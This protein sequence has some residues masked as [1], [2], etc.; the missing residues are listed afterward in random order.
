MKQANSLMLIVFNEYQPSFVLGFHGCDEEVG[1][2]ILRGEEDH[3]FLSEKNHDWLG[4]GIYFWEGNPSRA[5]E[6][7]KARHKLGKIQSPFVLGAIIDL[8]HCLDLFDHDGLAQVKTAHTLLKRTFKVAGKA[9]FK[10]SGRTPDKAGRVLDC[11]V[12]NYLHEYRNLSDEEEYD[13]VR[14][15]FLEG[16]KL[17][18]GAGFRSENHIQLCVRKEVCIKGYFRPLP[19]KEITLAQAN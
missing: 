8:R 13:S 2:R 16:P 11:A 10:N 3:L 5:L 17:Y 9:M 6:W 7:A 1:E 4:H 15:P 12:M 19:D 18:T 14:G